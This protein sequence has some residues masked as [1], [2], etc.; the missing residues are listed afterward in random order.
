[1]ENVDQNM[2]KELENGG[3]KLEGW[4]MQEQNARLENGDQKIQDHYSVVFSL[5]CLSAVC[6]QLIVHLNCCMTCSG[7][8][9]CV[10]FLRC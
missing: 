5:S 8:T 2:S 9:L 1:M 4:Q 3:P 6:N 7:K 10:Q